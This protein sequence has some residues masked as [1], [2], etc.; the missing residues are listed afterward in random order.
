M[1]GPAFRTRP[2]IVG[3]I[4]ALAVTLAGACDLN[5]HP[6]PPESDTSNGGSD[7]GGSVFGSPGSSSGAGVSDAGIGGLGGFGSSSGAPVVITS[8]GGA[9]NNPTGDDTGGDDAATG[10]DASTG[11]DATTGDAGAGDAGAGDA[12]AGDAGA[13]DAGI[14]SDGGEEG[15]SGVLLDASV[16]DAGD[17]G[18][19]RHSL[20]CHASAPGAC[21]RCAWPLNYSVCIAHECGCA[22]DGH[23]AALP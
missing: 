3:A 8:D 13:G 6:L 14:S 4:F 2:W 18:E 15:G 12:G 23:D 11:A 20:D 7:E 19:C 16:D 1:R 10:D 21:A 5:P 22:C 17:A 9:G